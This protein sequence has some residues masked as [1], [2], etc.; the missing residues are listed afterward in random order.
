MKNR[1]EQILTQ[2]CEAKVKSGAGR[3]SPVIENQTPRPQGT[4]LRAGG[5]AQAKSRHFQKV[6][7]LRP[8]ETE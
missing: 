8:Q 7:R 3:E 2:T 6:K 4:P 5:Q 1:E